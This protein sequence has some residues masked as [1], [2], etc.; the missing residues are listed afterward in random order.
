MTDSMAYADVVLPAC[1]HFEHADLYAAYGQQFLQRAEAVIPPVGESLPNT[2]IFRRLALKFGLSDPAFQER[3]DELMDAA[4]NLDDPRMHGMQA[5]RIPT[6]QAIRM[7]FAGDEPV[8]FHNV[9]PRTPSGRI[10][11][12]STLLGERYGAAL[13]IYRPVQSTYPLT[14]ITP[15]SDQRITSTFGGLAANDNPPVLAMNPVDASARGL[16][17]GRVVKIWNE[18]GQVYLPLHITATVRPGV[19]SSDKGAWLRTSPNGQTV[20]ALAPT[21]KADLAEGACYNDA[22]VEVAAE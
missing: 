6:D 11:L 14:L 4:M 5:S 3:D 10:E 17:D 1:T 20:S 19:V 7:E 13:P 22:R 9:L 21:H 8:L 12:E 2:E 16:V 15:A 18:L